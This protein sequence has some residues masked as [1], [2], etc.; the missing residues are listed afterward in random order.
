MYTKLREAGWVYHETAKLRNEKGMAASVEPLS[1]G[2][3]TPRHILVPV[4]SLLGTEPQK[5]QAS[6][7]SFICACVGSRLQVPSHPLPSTTT[8]AAGAWRKVGGCCSMSWYSME[9]DKNLKGGL[10]TE[11]FV[12]VMIRKVSILPLIHL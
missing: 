9:P 5:Q 7:R 12:I 10:K 8:V 2:S 1:Q 11:P 3:L 6:M 4:H